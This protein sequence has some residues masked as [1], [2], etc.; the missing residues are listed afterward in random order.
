MGVY[1]DNRESAVLNILEGDAF[2]KHLYSLAQSGF[3]GTATELGARVGSLATERELHHKS[4]PQN[5]RNISDRV[6][7]LAPALRVAG[8]DVERTRT[9]SERII[10]LIPQQYG[11]TSTPENIFD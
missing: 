1:A 8:I 2:S 7:R 10:Q 6:T 9:G 3:E 11:G 4:W 5:A